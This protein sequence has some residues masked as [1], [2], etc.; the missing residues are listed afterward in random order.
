MNELVIFNPQKGYL[1]DRGWI[2]NPN[3]K[4]IRI[5]TDI[6]KLRTRM[7]LLATKSVVGCRDLAR[8]KVFKLD[9]LHYSHPQPIA[10]VFSDETIPQRVMVDH[11]FEEMIGADEAFHLS[12]SLYGLINLGISLSE[13]GYFLRM[14]RAVYVDFAHKFP[15]RENLPS[16]Y[17]K[18]FPTGYDIVAPYYQ[19]SQFLF[20]N[21]KRDMIAFKLAEEVPLH[22]H[23]FKEIYEKAIQELSA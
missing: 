13:V 21:D 15:D 11:V 3:D 6:S 9:D 10:P 4:S 7:I 8:S 23:D 22:A 18:F 20:F 1:G 14:T 16:S 19:S 12:G 5:F 2:L 17:R